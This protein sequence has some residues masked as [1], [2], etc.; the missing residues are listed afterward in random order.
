[1]QGKIADMYTTLSACRS[2]VYTIAR[3]VDSGHNSSK[4]SCDA[5]CRSDL[6]SGC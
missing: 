3:A 5:L 6:A 4:V 1:M 2:Y